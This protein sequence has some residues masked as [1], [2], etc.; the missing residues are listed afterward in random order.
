MFPNN[1]SFFFLLLLLWITEADKNKFIFYERRLV[2]IMKAVN[3]HYA[4]VT[5][6]TREICGGGAGGCYVTGWC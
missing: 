5:Q 2:I 1:E 3:Y 6:L 4:T